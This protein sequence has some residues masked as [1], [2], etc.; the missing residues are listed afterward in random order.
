MAKKEP[1][2]HHHWGCNLE[3]PSLHHN[4]K[5]S[6]NFFFN[7]ESGFDILSSLIPFKPTCLRREGFALDRLSHWMVS[8]EKGTSHLQPRFPHL[9]VHR[10]CGRWQITGMTWQP[11][12]VSWPRCW[13][14]LGSRNQK[15]GELGRGKRG[16]GAGGQRRVRTPESRHRMPVPQRP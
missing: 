3:H 1:S 16:S 13:L 8:W 7:E 12:W 10:G 9:P 6:T 2:A 14:D 11:G 4:K 15:P 5:K